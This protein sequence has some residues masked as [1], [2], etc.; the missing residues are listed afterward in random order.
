MLYIAVNDLKWE[1]IA[2]L[3]R[4][5]YFSNAFIFFDEIVSINW[6]HILWK[7]SVIKMTLKQS[8]EWNLINIFSYAIQRS[9]EVNIAIFFQSQYFANPVIFFNETSYG[10]RNY[11]TNYGKCIIKYYIAA[12]DAYSGNF[13]PYSG[14]FTGIRVFR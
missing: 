3:F 7:Y 4:S 6:F 13:P 2:I 1:Q 11:H 12:Y 5:Q 10:H 14:N 9:C 8:S